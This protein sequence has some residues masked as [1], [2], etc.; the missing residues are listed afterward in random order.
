MVA[1][2]GKVHVSGILKG[3]RREQ[4][5]TPNFLNEVYQAETINA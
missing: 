1:E 5:R 4:G 2:I 3:V